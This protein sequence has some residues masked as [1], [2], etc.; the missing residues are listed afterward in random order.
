LQNTPKQLKRHGEKFH[1]EK[2]VCGKCF[3]K[4]L[5][6]G[7]EEHLKSKSHIQISP[8][9]F[10]YC[11]ISKESGVGRVCQVGRSAEWK[12]GKQMWFQFYGQGGYLG[13]QLR[14]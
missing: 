13:Y 6:K 8:E 14:I 3:I 11:M 1:S 9:K 7:V 5:A 2:R 10:R 12:S 4:V